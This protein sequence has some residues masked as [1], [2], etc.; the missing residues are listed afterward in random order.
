[1]YFSLTVIPTVTTTVAS[2][3]TAPVTAA[4]LITAESLLNGNYITIKHYVT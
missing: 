2:I 3:T 4:L 1:M